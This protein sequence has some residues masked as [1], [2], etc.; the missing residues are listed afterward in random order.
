MVNLPSSIQNVGPSPDE[1]FNVWNPTLDYNGT[2][3][4]STSISKS[5]FEDESTS[6]ADYEEYLETLTSV[7]HAP[8]TVL[9]K[10]SSHHGA[11]LGQIDVDQTQNLPV[12][13][14]IGVTISTRLYSQKSVTFCV[15]EDA[16]NGYSV[17]V[18]QEDAE[19]EVRVGWK[20]YASRWENGSTLKYTVST[21]TFEST[22]WAALV[23]REA[24]K[25]TS[26]WQNIGARFQE[27]E[28]DEKATFAIKYCF[29]PDNCRPDVYA[30]AFFPK[31]SRGELIVYQLALEPSNV[32]F[33]ANILAHE[34]GHILG[35]SH[36]FAHQTSFLWGKTNVRSAMN[37]FSDLNQLEV[38]QQDREELA[39]YYECDAGQHGGLFIT[40]IEPRLYQFPRSDKSSI[41][42]HRSASKRLY[43][44]CRIRRVRFRRSPSLIKKYDQRT[45]SSRILL[46]PI[47]IRFYF[48]FAI[49]ASFACCAFLLGRM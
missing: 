34:L 25:A 5:T 31:T 9:R 30:R 14:R 44:N 4:K 19:R 29:E 41:R 16:A 20:G 8:C 45:K 38:G 39:S 49:F 2:S 47:L 27:V 17:C 24:A 42:R 12:G 13:P 3:S 48:G 40:D 32:D 33:L 35:L 46:S 21:E 26:M 37:Y 23:A 28:R 36:E 6:N 11:G 15:P 18:T 22:R 10:K 7:S 1:N 43:L